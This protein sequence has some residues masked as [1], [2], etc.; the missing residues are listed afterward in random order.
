MSVAVFMNFMGAGLLAVFTPLGLRWGHGKF[1][2]LFA[3]LSAFGFILVSNP[4]FQFVHSS[5]TGT[6]VVIGLPVCT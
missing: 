4:S 2:G 6:D 5:M 3:G 1:L